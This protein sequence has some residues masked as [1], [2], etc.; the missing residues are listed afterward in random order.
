MGDKISKITFDEYQ[1]TLSTITKYIESEIQIIKNRQKNLP[2]IKGF[3]NFKDFI[4]TIERRALKSTAEELNL[5][6]TTVRDRWR[7]LTLPTPVYSAIERGEVSF[8]KAKLMTPIRFDFNNSQ[9]IDV[10]EEMIEEI[11]G[12]LNNNEIKEL[13][14]Q[15]SS[16]VWNHTSVA[17]ERIIEQLGVKEDSRF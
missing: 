10:A 11:K 13:V 1:N 12:G 3:K 14:K 6:S 2:V 17:T 9:D 8:S 15:N 4:K 16:R 7:V 5:G